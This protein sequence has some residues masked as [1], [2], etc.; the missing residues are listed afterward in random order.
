M[1]NPHLLFFFI[2]TTLLLKG[3]QS[4][5][6]I[7][8]IIYNNWAVHVVPIIII[9]GS[10]SGV[11]LRASYLVFVSLTPETGSCW[12]TWFTKMYYNNRNVIQR[13]CIRQFLIERV[14]AGF[15]FVS[16]KL[17]GRTN[18]ML[19]CKSAVR[20]RPV[21]ILC[22]YLNRYFNLVHQ[23][24]TIIIYN[25]HAT[26]DTYLDDFFGRVECFKRQAILLKQ[27]V[28]ASNRSMG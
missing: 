17:S 19:F 14:L 15:T 6:F 18:N 9:N 27:R 23:P 24:V 25:Q 11:A 12:W 7:Q 10:V 21:Q 4:K 20:T 22:F 28:I 2:V 16:Q 5:V 3:Y 13:D 8:L 26:T 1:S